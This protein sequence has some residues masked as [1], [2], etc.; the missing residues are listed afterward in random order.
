[1]ALS[2]AELVTFLKPD[3]QG[4]LLKLDEKAKVW[5]RRYCVLTDA[6]LF[7]YTEQDPSHAKGEVHFVH[8]FPI[9]T[10]FPMSFPSV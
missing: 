6:T 4:F 7:L 1:M 9:F 8:F 3:C 2:M 10:S 5:K